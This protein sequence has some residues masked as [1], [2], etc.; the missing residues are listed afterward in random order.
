M[1]R[2]PAL[3]AGLLV[4]LCL[5][6]SPEA[7]RAAPPP[8]AQAVRTLFTHPEEPWLLEFMF[9]QNPAL[10]QRFASEA[11][12]VLT[13]SQ[14]ER[15]SFQMRWRREIASTAQSYHGELTSE[16]R[17]GAPTVETMVS[18]RER[19]MTTLRV[20]MRFPEKEAEVA[21]RIKLGNGHLSMD[22]LGI[23]RPTVED[24][25]RNAR[26]SESEDIAGYIQS[27]LVVAARQYREPVVVAAAPEEQLEQAAVAPPRVQPQA[28]VLADV[29]RQPAARP[30]A[31]T[32]M[33]AAAQPRAPTAF[34]QAQLAA[35]NAN[36]ARVLDPERA[37]RAAD[38]IPS[39]S[40]PAEGVVI[41][42]HA[43]NTV[44]PVVPP[45]TEV[46]D[47]PGP[48][49]RVE[50]P[51]PPSDLSGTGRS[52]PRLMAEH[53]AVNVA[54]PLLGALVGVGIALAFALPIVGIVLAAVLGAALGMFAG[55]ML[56][57]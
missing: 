48:R 21:D 6:A 23:A 14:Q 17:S 2:L 10:R 51:T 52:T 19:A 40:A 56:Q 29:R 50:P 39:G 37:H 47:A 28:P 1:K 32:P 8:S 38:T 27:D 9:R 18:R 54:G 49:P 13:G 26:R 53:A 55:N 11:Q 30:I 15:T 5:A 16:I 4:C 25:V 24:H 20:K 46:R 45:E 22:F 36:A 35:A 44:V 3:A 31:H 7:V 33:L 42:A 34:E 43:E 57:K 12:Q 41:P